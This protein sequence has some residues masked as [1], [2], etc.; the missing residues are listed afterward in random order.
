MDNKIYKSIEDLATQFNLKSADSVSI[1]LNK[2]YGIV[3]FKNAETIGSAQQIPAVAEDQGSQQSVEQQLQELSQRKEQLFQ[4]RNEKINTLLEQNPDF[5]THI[6]NAVN[7]SSGVFANSPSG[8]EDET[9][10]NTVG[11][12]YNS[13]ISSFEQQ[14]SQDLE[15][16]KIQS[17]IDALDKQEVELSQKKESEN[18]QD[19]TTEV[20]PQEPEIKQE[21]PSSIQAQVP[22]GQTVGQPQTVA[23]SNQSQVQSPQV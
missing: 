6:P 20:K 16:G 9:V 19:Q 11:P 22:E 23:Q 14:V 10:N 18:K 7:E 2:D 1:S 12:K 8:Q 13:I 3:K 5:A 15:I 21:S 4:Q 17:E